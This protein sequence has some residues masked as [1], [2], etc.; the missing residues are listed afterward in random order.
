VKAHVPEKHL[1]EPD[2]RLG[3]ADQESDDEAAKKSLEDTAN[4]LTRINPDAVASLREGLEE[5]LTVM[6]LGRSG[7]LRRTVAT[8]QSLRML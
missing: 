1:P 3:A 8:D 4:W 5:A 6:R 2:Q 7:A